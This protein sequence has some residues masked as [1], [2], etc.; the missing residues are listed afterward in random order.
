VETEGIMLELVEWEMQAVPYQD[1][2][3][4]ARTN[5]NQQITSKLSKDL[6][7]D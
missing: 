7:K 5:N 3:E 1:K 4:M 2:G 6:D